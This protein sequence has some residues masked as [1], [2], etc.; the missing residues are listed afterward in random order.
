MPNDEGENSA[1]GLGY[2]SFFRHSCLGICHSRVVL[3][4]SGLS[5]P[6]LMPLFCSPRQPRPVPASRKT[7][8]KIAHSRRMVHALREREA[9]G[10]GHAS[11]AGSRSLGR[12][13]SGRVTSSWI[14]PTS[15]FPRSSWCPRCS[16]YR[17][18]CNPGPRGPEHQPR[19][20]ARAISSRSTILSFEKSNKFLGNPLPPRDQKT[21]LRSSG[22]SPTGQ[23]LT[24]PT[25]W[26]P[27]SCWW[28]C[29][30][31][32]WSSWPASPHRYA[33]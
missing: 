20:S 12:N 7:A 22:K 25:S 5:F 27:L 18:C 3:E 9:Q 17:L 2:S 6:E 32:R 1:L 8:N 26:F 31:L 14:H 4:G 29:R 15:S 33:E 23:C 11:T 28:S 10:A 19:S 21:V 13:R 30:R 24:I 16:W